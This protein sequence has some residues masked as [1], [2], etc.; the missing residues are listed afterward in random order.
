MKRLNKYEKSILWSVI[1]IFSVGALLHMIYD[2]TNENPIVALFAPVNESIWE[3]TK[4]V[5]LP[6]FIWYM[7]AYFIIKRFNKQMASMY[8]GC[9]LAA[10][11]ISIIFIPLLY[12]FYTGAFGIQSM[13]IDILIL[14]AAAALG[15]LFSLFLFKYQ[16]KIVNAYITISIFIIIFIIYG[17]F[18]LYPPGI[19]LFDDVS[20]INRFITLV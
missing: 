17:Y 12:Y 4:M 9:G 14:L 19:P 1:F 20:V 6:S 5:V 18:T 11:I 13:I 2:F 10:M 8:L 7:G 3:H 16:K 15:A